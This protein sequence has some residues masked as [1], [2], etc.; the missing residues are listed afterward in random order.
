MRKTIIFTL[1]MITVFL[2][3]GCSGETTLPIETT[4]NETSTLSTGITT[5]EITTIEEATTTE[6][7][8]VITEPIAALIPE[9]SNPYELFVSTTGYDI[10]YIDLYEE[11]KKNDG[12]NQLLMMIDLDLFSGYINLVTDEEITN[13]INEFSYGTDDPYEIAAFTNEEILFM[14]KTFQDSMYILG[15]YNNPDEYIKVIVAREL[16]ALDCLND[17]AN[18]EELWYTNAANVS[19]YYETSYFDDIKAIKIKF[20][21]EADAD[22]VMEKFNLVSLDGLDLREYKGWI[23][24]EETLV[25]PLDEIVEAYQTIDVYYFNDANNIVDS[26]NHVVYE[27]G[28]NDIYFDADDLE[29]SFN[30]AGDLVNSV[31]EVIIEDARLFDDLESAVDYKEANTEYYLVTR[32]NPYDM[33]ETINVINA[34]DEVVFTIDPAGHIFDATGTD[35]T[36]TTD[37]YVNKVYTAIEDL[38]LTTSNN[39]AEL[40]DDEVLQKYILMYNYVYGDYK[41]IVDEMS[42]YAD[43][44]SNDAFIFDYDSI[45]K[46]NGSLPIYLYETLGT[47]QNTL[48][49]EDDIAFYTHE[50]LKLLDN[51]EYQYYMVLNLDRSEKIDVSDFDGDETTLITLI[52]QDVYDSVSNILNESNLD[53]TTFVSDRVIDFRTENDLI[54]YDYFLG[55]DYI[56]LNSSFEQSEAGHASVV[57]S[58]GDKEITADQLLAY[59][60]SVN[61]PLYTLYASQVKAVVDAHYADVYCEADDT[62]I[63]DI[64]INESDAKV[65]IVED[66]ENLKAQF[67]ASYYSNYYTFEEFIYLAY[68]AKSETDFLM[69]Y[70]MKYS[71]QPLF[72]Y[73]QIISDDYL[74]LNSLLE[75]SQTYYDNYFNLGVEHIL[76]FVDRDEDGLPD[77]YDRFYAELE[78]AVAYDLKLSDF[79][80]AIRTYLDDSD[81]SLA[82]LKSDYEQARLD[83]AT[84]GEFRRYGFFLISE[85]L[86]NLSYKDAVGTFEQSFVDALVD[87][88]KDYQSPLRSDK[89]YIYDDEFIQT[90]YGVHLIK[91]SNINDFE[92]PSA[93]FTMT[94]DL[95]GVAEYLSGMVNLTDELTLEQLMIYA[96]YRFSEI[97]SG[98]SNLEEIY[99]LVSPDIPSSV[100][101][102]IDEYISS[103]YDELYT[104]GYLNVIIANQLLDGN[105]EN[106][107]STYCDITEVEFNTKLEHII[108]I[109]MYR[110]FASYNQTE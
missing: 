76:I 53:S 24:Q 56:L 50:P 98:V 73:D 62:C 74:I 43:V 34:L 49:E 15:Y 52:G 58:Y 64:E 83:D 72:I 80:A 106:T 68:G 35:V 27:L 94:Y 102:A 79:Q 11:I 91:A 77:D 32:D 81:N 100:M 26:D 10:T 6:V 8:T 55:V 22:L 57:A 66:L 86:G 3:I 20:T 5:E 9:I 104:V 93:S 85:N 99:G 28:T 31:S 42:T 63:Y 105:Y 82:S 107:I 103:I 54:I 12:L 13:K 1:I 16:Y 19:N 88:Y 61:A 4:S 7:T 78:D 96:D 108:E 21:S 37:I 39:S 2:L 110:I 70:F 33:D 89:E 25:D 48:N 14:D 60:L 90:P 87:I 59:A 36:Y 51:E 69:N 67:E 84:W 45:L 17:N 44:L 75:L 46:A 38:T 101:V 65:K 18:S 97:A 109:Y 95:D 92:Q 23:Y 41:D 71:L 47:Y 30:T 40:T 29:Y